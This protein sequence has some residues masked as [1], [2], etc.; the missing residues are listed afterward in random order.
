MAH[1]AFLLDTDFEQIEYTQPKDLLEAKGHQTTL[2]TTQPNKQVQGLNHS[3]KGDTFTAD[4]LIHEAKVADFD[5][6]VLP[7]GTVNADAL[8]FNPDAQAM[9]KAFNDAGKPVAAICHTPW[10]FVDTKLAR[11]KR[12]TA[13]K[14]VAIDLQNAGATYEDKSVV[15]DGNFITSREPKDIPDFATAIDEALAK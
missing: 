3:D 5:A 1:I 6:I 10:I 9:V 2:I 7:G 15:V 11:G 12:L 13:Y 8:R 4:L 14:T